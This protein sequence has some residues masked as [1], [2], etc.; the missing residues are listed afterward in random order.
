M[1]AEF[2]E[3][4]ESGGLAKMTKKRWASHTLSIRSQNF[5][6]LRKNDIE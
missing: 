5:F 4:M 2:S 6:K 3:M 1:S